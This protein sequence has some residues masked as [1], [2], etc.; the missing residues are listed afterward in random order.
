MKQAETK[1]NSNTDRKNSMSLG[2]T[3]ASKD[4][5]DSQASRTPQAPRPLQSR[6]MRA[7]GHGIRAAALLIMTA[8]LLAGFT[9]A[10]KGYSMYQEALAETSLQD[11]IEEIQ[12]KEGYT[13]LADLPETYTDAVVAVEDHRFYQHGGLDFIAIA[14]AVLHDI[15]AGRYVEGGS[16]IT[17]QLAKNLYFSQEKELTRKAAEVFMAYTLEASFTKDEILELYVNSIYFGEGYNTVGEASQG[18]FGKAPEDMSEY[19]STLL[20]GI[21]NAPSR[22]APTV[23][24]ELAAKRQ[25]QVLRRME[26]C[27]YF[28]ETEA[29]T[30][31]AQMVAME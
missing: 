16:T 3:E 22:Y 24:P 5:R 21:P 29:E 15:Q 7:L 6:L 20:A 2:N 18:Y 28:S 10:G 31:A 4:P 27:G 26:A 9:I 30:V 12:S 1:N 19:E 13:E 25:L 11:K 23:H 14:R 8:A 17:Q